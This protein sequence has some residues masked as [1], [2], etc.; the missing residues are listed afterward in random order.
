MPQVPRR[1]GKY[2]LGGS[3]DTDL[4]DIDDGKYNVFTATE[5]TN[6][7]LQEAQAAYPHYT[8]FASFTIKDKQG[9]DVRTLD[10]QYT[11]ELDQLPSE[12]SELYYFL[13]GTAHKFPHQPGPDKNGRKRIKAK[14]NVGDPPTG[15]YP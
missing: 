9:N 13:D 5:E 10:K 3:K 4:E 15:A 8:W 14:L 11:I 6:K 7:K 1:G 12:N 2:G